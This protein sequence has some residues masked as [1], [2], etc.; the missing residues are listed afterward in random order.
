MSLSLRTMALGLVLVLAS[1]ILTTGAGA[2]PHSEE[3]IA[4]TLVRAIHDNDVD[5]F[6][7]L[8]PTLL[9]VQFWARN[10]LS[11]DD[12]DLINMEWWEGHYGYLK[13]D[14]AEGQAR[15]GTEFPVI[16]PS[17]WTLAGHGEITDDGSRLWDE[18]GRLMYA[19][20]HATWGES[21]PLRFRLRGR[22][23]QA[24]HHAQPRLRHAP[25]GGQRGDADHDRRSA[26]PQ[27]GMA[28]RDQAGLDSSVWSVDGCWAV[29]E[30]GSKLNGARGAVR[31]AL[32]QYLDRCT[33]SLDPQRAVEQ[34]IAHALILA[35]SDPM[36]CLDIVQITV[37]LGLIQ[38]E[39]KDD[40]FSKAAPFSKRIARSRSS[41]NTSPFPV[42][43]S[44]RPWRILNWPARPSAWGW[45]WSQGTST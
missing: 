17:G 18:S 29:G 44:R 1:S 3:E 14:F 30:A 13:E 2:K 43:T 7:S 9:E 36:D 6:A 40:G 8:F 11:Q 19:D 22:Q 39:Q 21:P 5:T 31:R 16:E 20:L 23:A 28:L 24:A 26:H 32:V 38:R 35:E 25:A 15:L 41:R 33:A 10:H 37:D 12:Q 4:S 34:I 27:G 42:P 45:L